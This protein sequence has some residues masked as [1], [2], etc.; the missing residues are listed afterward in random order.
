[1]S[2]LIKR[3]KEPDISTSVTKTPY[4]EDLKQPKKEHINH[5]ENYQK[6]KTQQAR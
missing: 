6:C 3:E 2:I 4:K 1:M 5:S